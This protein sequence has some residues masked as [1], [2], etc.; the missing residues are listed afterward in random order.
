MVVFY[1]EDNDNVELIETNKK[2]KSNNHLIISSLK[3]NVLIDDTLH[4]ITVISNVCEFKRRWELMRDFIARLENYPNVKLYVVEMAYGNQDFHITSP[5]N[6]LHLQLRTKFALWHKENMINIAIN[7]LLPID[8]KAVAWIDG[9]IEFENP[10]WVIDSLKILTQFDIIQLFTTCFDLDENQK[11]MRIFQSFGYKYAHGEEFIAR[12]NFGDNL[13]HSGYAWA[14]TR[15]FYEKI[16]YIYDR[17]ILGSGDYVVSQALV[18]NLGCRN[19]KMPG[20][21]SDLKNYVDKFKNFKVG[22]IPCNIIHYFHGSKANRKYTERIQILL[23]YN[24][25]PNFHICYDEQGIIIPSQYMPI[26][27]IDDINNY[28]FERNEDE[29][30]DLIQILNS[31]QN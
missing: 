30:Y 23:K 11:P 28:F 12:K 14:C 8:W 9:D 18:G 31:N 24:Y 21:V 27:F 25:D 20:Y 22:Y 15:E 16:G 5:T 10:N 26:N 3:N 6:P 4:V 2:I 29:F 19:A 7:K 17:G 1:E 13:W